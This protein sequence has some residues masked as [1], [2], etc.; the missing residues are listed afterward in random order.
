MGRRI[1]PGRV[2]TVGNL[3]RKSKMSA[4]QLAVVLVTTCVGG[5]IILAPNELIMAA[6]QGAWVSIIL[7]G[8]LY[9]T[10]SLLCIKIG[11]YY[12]QESLVEF[13]PRIFGKGIG[14]ALT[15]WLWV[16]YFILYAVI[17]QGLSRVIGL[18][19]FD[20]TPVEV[21]GAGMAAVTVYCALQ[22][23]G[24]ILR[25]LQLLMFSSVPMLV[26]IWLLTFFNFLPE[27]LLPLWP[28]D[29]KGVV[30][31]IGISWGMFSGYEVILL[32]L[33]L[34]YR[35]KIAFAW[36]VG[37]AFGCMG[38]I[39][40]LV[41]VVAVGVLTV[42]GAQN[43]PYPTLIVIRG[44]EL[45]GTFIERLENYLLVAWIP[46][47]FDTLAMML[48]FVSETCRRWLKYEDHRPF[49]LLLAPAAFIL[50]VVL[51][52][53]KLYEQAGKL[54]NT[55]GLVFSLFVIPLAYILARIKRRDARDG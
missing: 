19:M 31:G 9:Y 1:G 17:L 21:I 50:N 24:T 32:L 18:F 33:P 51:D 35:G 20:R 37:C 48:Y 42:K 3:E 22:D 4:L 44:V 11:E 10:V 26:G 16:T 41:V 39:F 46:I 2:M 23:W 45:P 34:V 43:V 54:T 40:V 55:M 5:Q 6:G 12:P 29:F 7:G 25:V 38:F 53:A 49:V 47:V 30:K 15:G 13:F 52:T 36:A 8:M 27:N 14:L 28:L